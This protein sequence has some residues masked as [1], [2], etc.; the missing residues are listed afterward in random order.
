MHILSCVCLCVRVCVCICGYANAFEIDPGD[1][2][3]AQKSQ[4]TFIV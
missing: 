1:I 4:N 3:G 2:F